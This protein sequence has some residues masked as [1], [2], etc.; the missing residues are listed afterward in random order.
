M[1]GKIETE[2]L[3]RAGMK[4]GVAGATVA[5]AIDALKQAGVAAPTKIPWVK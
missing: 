3:I 5:K 4:P 2:A 1:I